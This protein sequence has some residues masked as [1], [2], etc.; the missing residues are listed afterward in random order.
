ML[1][2]NSENPE[3]HKFVYAFLALI[4]SACTT[5]HAESA[6]FDQDV[7]V[8][9]LNGLPLMRFGVF[10]FDASQ[11][12]ESPAM[13]R[14]PE[15]K[16][17]DDLEFVH[18]DGSRH[19][20]VRSTS[21]EGN[22]VSIKNVF[23]ESSLGKEFLVYY[24][25]VFAPQ[26]IAGAEFE[27]AAPD[28]G[29]KRGSYIAGSTADAIL[30]GAAARGPVSEARGVTIRFPDGHSAVLAFSRDAQVSI[31]KREREEG[32]L[33]ELTIMVP[34]TETEFTITASSKS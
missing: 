30:S 3:M 2:I 17:G 14:D 4:A 18:P 24:R 15:I 13:K 31:Y 8:L 10:M 7:V 12:A 26:E 27:F 25:T 33:L 34:V 22:E 20:L 1:R 5:L 21:A 28:K 9:E 6:S 32:I 29:S 16:G 11:T 19:K 23:E